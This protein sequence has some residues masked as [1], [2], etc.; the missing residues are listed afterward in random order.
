MKRRSFGRQLLRV[1][2]TLA[3]TAVLVGPSTHAA[4]APA[5]PGFTPVPGHDSSE[6]LMM[7]LHCG[8]GLT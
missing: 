2:A 5:T 6:W 1:V 3:V 8:A 4:S 7:G